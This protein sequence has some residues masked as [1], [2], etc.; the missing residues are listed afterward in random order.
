M[1]KRLGEF[2]TWEDALKF[3]NGWSY[4]TED[5]VRIHR[6][7]VPDELGNCHEIFWECTVE[8]PLP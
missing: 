7:F 4:V 2:H 3:A 5:H 8:I 1:V 6:E